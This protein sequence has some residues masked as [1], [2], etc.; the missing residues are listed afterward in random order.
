VSYFVDQGF[1]VIAP[2]YRSSGG[3][4]K[5]LGEV[6]ATGQ[7]ETDDVAGA[8]EYL[9]RLPSVDGTRIGAIG[10]SF[11]G[12]IALATV[13]HRPETFAAAVEMYGPTDLLAWYQQTPPLRPALRAGLGGTPDERPDAYR[14][15]S[16]VNFA[17]RVR[18]PLLI[19]H[20]DADAEVP[21][22]QARGMADALQRAH[23]DYELVIV[24]GGDHGF[25]MTGSLQAMETAMR[26][27]LAHLLRPRR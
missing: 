4:S 9:R 6:D 24:P 1:V 11:G 5:E 26:F 8:V 19:V 27:M 14:T 18:T 21:V 15:A 13:T 10:F 16:P 7:K 22:S 23:K 2:N 25:V 12:L 20:G 17:D 3:Y